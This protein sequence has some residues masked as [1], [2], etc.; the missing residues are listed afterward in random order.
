MRGNRTRDGQVCLSSAYADFL[1]RISCVTH[2]YSYIV[3]VTVSSYVWFDTDKLLH[4]KCVQYL[5]PLSYVCWAYVVYIVGFLFAIHPHEKRHLHIFI[6]LGDTA[7]TGY[8]VSAV[9][10]MCDRHVGL[11]KRDRHVLAGNGHKGKIAGRA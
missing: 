1:V 4:A 6:P 8:A 2:A 10:L 5:A 3:C 9:G 7:K 11:I